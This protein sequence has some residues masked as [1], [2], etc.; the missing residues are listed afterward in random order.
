MR[1]II[2]YDISGTFWFVHSVDFLVHSLSFDRLMRALSLSFLPTRI[3]PT[4]ACA[5]DSNPRVRINHSYYLLFAIFS[6]VL[7]FAICYFLSCTR[8]DA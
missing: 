2:Q 6:H 1:I 3:P 4:R 8:S 7:S 5:R